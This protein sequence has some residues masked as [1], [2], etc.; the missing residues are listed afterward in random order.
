[1]RGFRTFGVG[2][3]DSRAPNSDENS[4]I[5]SYDSIGG[6]AV[7]AA[8]AA[9]SF[10]LPHPLLQKFGIHGHVFG[11]AGN[12]TPLSDVLES[13]RDPMK[14][15]KDFVSNI[16]A[17]AGVGIVLPTPLGRIEVQK[18]NGFNRLW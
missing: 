7:F 16:R 8:T 14:F 4:S 9:L 17:S 3:T 10:D 5:T 11:C 12:L 2:P 18:I 13:K 6:D 1:M 15:S